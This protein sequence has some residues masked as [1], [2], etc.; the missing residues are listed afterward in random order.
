MT[1]YSRKETP[2]NKFF[3]YFKV[4]FPHFLLIMSFVFIVQ[5]VLT[6]FNPNL[7]LISMNNIVCCLELILYFSVAFVGALLYVIDVY[8]KKS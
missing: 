6:L 3:K 8:R 2:M 4:L 7:G 5:W 1:Y